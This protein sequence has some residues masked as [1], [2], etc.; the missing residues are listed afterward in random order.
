MSI[1]WT[2]KEIEILKKMLGAHKTL[3]EVAQ[4]LK[5]RT[6]DGIRKNSM[7]RD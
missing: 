1:K 2:D 5:S 4:V 7:R 3:E 6:L